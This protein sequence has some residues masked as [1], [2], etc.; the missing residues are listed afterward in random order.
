MGLDELLD[1]VLGR[2]HG[3]DVE[4]GGKPKLV[5]GVKVECVGGG[6]VEGAV[7]SG[8]GDEALAI[9]D[10]GGQGAEGLGV[11]GEV[12]EVDKGDVQVLGHDLE[13]LALG[14]DAE[15]DEGA[16]HPKSLGALEGL[17]LGELFRGD[18]A[19]GDEDVRD[20]HGGWDGVGPE[21]FNWEGRDCGGR[22]SERDRPNGLRA[23]GR[24]GM[25]WKRVQG[26]RASSPECAFITSR[27]PGGPTPWASPRRAVG[28]DISPVPR[29]CFKAALGPARIAQRD[30]LHAAWSA[31]VPTEGADEASA[32]ERGADLG[33]LPQGLQ[34]VEEVGGNE[35]GGAEDDGGRPGSLG[36]RHGEL[37]G[38]RGEGFVPDATVGKQG[39]ECVMQARPVP[40]VD[41]LEP[42]KGRIGDREPA[43]QR[44]DG[45][46]SHPS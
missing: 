4:A 12:G 35:D 43:A 30:R 27:R 32:R 45:E 2:Q 1:V 8:D 20:A 39:C 3:L 14:E 29:G 26:L 21:R 31:C 24:T 22:P 23:A 37:V 42:L 19:P 9:D 36:R 17:G 33:G 15:L 34:P 10:L 11:G 18:Q 25:P 6:D 28:H 40:G 13:D 44:R 38:Q 7:A 16:V 46:T 5:E 41:G